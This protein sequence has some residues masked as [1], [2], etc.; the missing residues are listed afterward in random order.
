MLLEVILSDERSL[1]EVALQLL[2]FR[3]D[4]HV[5]GQVRLLSERLLA[6]R[7]F[8]VFLTWQK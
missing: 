6:D 1:A 8:V 7:A 2:R 3:V 5:R 4:Q